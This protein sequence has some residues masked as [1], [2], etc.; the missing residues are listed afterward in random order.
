MKRVGLRRRPRLLGFHAKFIWVR[1]HLHNICAQIYCEQPSHKIFSSKI[2][3]T[4][5]KYPDYKLVKFAPTFNIL[6]Y[7]LFL[8]TFLNECVVS[9]I[10]SSISIPT[11][12]YVSW[13]FDQ[14][15]S[16]TYGKYRKPKSK[17]F[18]AP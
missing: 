15:L 14:Y 6:L 2:S 4:K 17:P 1:T 11:S 8:Y 18:S 5:S 16:T 3:S 7:L 13:S 9:Y 12:L 10:V